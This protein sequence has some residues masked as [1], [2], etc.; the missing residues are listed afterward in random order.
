[1]SILQEYEEIE[2][3]IG[4]GRVRTTDKYIKYCSKHGREILYSDIV[5]KK[6]EYELFDK[7]FQEEI[8][9][10]EITNIDDKIYSVSLWQ[11]FFD[12]D[13]VE[14][15]KIRPNKYGDGH[16][17]NDAFNHHLRTKFKNLH[18]R[19]KYDSENGMF[20]VWCQSI[21][22]AEEVAYE[23]SSLYK[24]EKKMIELIKYIKEKLGYA[25]DCD[26]KI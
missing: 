25:F 20:C 5:Y 1:M 13:W 11:N 18:N 21:Q 12:Y 14:E 17:Y 22:D 15:K 4:V 26:V 7:W 3:I 10:F 24:N 2:K 6:E 16:C 9:P 8:K 19:L 23:L